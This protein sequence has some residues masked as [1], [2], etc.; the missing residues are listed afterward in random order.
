MRKAQ[1]LIIGGGIAG[2][3]AAEFIRMNDPSGSITIVME[4]PETLY[5]RVLLPHYL[6]DQVLYERL[7]VRKPESYTEKNIDLIKGV[8]ADKVNTQNNQ[9][10]LSSGDIIEY[11]KLLVASGGKVNRFDVPGKDLK[12]VT[13]L[14]TIKDI[15][16]I[17]ELMNKA[18]NGAVIGGGFIGI[19][20][21]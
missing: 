4:E 1:Y 21:A 9:V 15:K 3:T 8:R 18:K 5:S 10:E 19:E 20:Y 12:G 11:E 6:R 14:R 2:T 7:Y 17:K 16:G 13:Y